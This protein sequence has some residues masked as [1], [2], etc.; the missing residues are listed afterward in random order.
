MKAPLGKEQGRYRKGKQGRHH[1]QGGYHK[2]KHLVWCAVRIKKALVKLAVR[3]NI[4]GR[5]TTRGKSRVIKPQGR[6]IQ[7]GRKMRGRETEW[8]RHKGENC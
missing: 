1:E 5:H 7:D 2:G 6:K 4:R 8:E 3:G